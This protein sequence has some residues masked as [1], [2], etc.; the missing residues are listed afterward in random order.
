VTSTRPSEPTVPSAA[1]STLDRSHPSPFPDPIP[2]IIPFG[3][4]T[5]FAGAPAVGKTTMLAEWCQR[6]RDGKTICG[7]PTHP[8]TAFCYITGDRP[9]SEYQ[10]MFD[11]VG[12]RDIP[13][14]AVVED[15]SISLADL[16]A[17]FKAAETFSKILDRLNIPPGAHVFVDPISPLFVT[18]DPNRQRDVAVSMIGFSRRCY[19]RQINLTCT[20]H[21]G[22]QKADPKQRYARPQDRIAGSTSFAGFSCTQIYFCDPELPKQPYSLLG[23]NPRHHAPEDFKFV[24]NAEGL[25][26]PYQGGDVLLGPE[27]SLEAV[28]KALPPSP[29]DVSLETVVADVHVHSGY[30]RATVKRALQTLIREGRALRMGRGRYRAISPA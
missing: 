23:W 7:H 15:T 16:R 12:F 18:G 28:L 9:W 25:F 4:V 24:R 29:H 10:P 3:T 8:P 30:S 1:S 21:F 19:E 17:P 27:A 14:Y 5:L 2:G 22:K 13:H 11:A 20:V 26:I 6:W